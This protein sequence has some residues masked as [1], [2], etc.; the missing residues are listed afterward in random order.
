MHLHAGPSLAA[1]VPDFSQDQLDRLARSVEARRQQL[2]EDINAYVARKQDEL[3]QYEHE[4]GT[5]PHCAHSCAHAPGAGRLL[6][7]LT[8][9][10]L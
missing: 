3:R 9:P 7:R 6:Q 5:V 8:Q 10:S 1:E 4:V 2:E